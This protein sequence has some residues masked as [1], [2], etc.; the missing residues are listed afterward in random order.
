MTTG[1]AAPDPGRLTTGNSSMLSCRQLSV[2]V[3]ANLSPR[4]D[5]TKFF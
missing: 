2:S 1:E 3:N 4:V 5:F